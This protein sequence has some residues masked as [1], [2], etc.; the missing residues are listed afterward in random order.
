MLVEF[1]STLYRDSGILYP[2]PVKKWEWTFGD[3]G[4]ASTANPTHTYLDTGR[5]I[6]K[7][8]ITTI[9]GCVIEDTMLIEVRL[10]ANGYLFARSGYT[11]SVVGF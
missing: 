9:Q 11:T 5:F 10:L 1:N 6:A 7:I 4:T 3:G 2:Y 8:K